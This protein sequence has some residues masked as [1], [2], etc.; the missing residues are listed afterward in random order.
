[1]DLKLEE[2][3]YSRY[4]YSW[5]KNWCLITRYTWALNQSWNWYS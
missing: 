2:K 1:M 4:W 5:T 3:L